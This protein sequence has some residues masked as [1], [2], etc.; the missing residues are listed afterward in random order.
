MIGAREWTQCTAQHREWRGSDPSC[1][2]H[3][4]SCQGRIQLWRWPVSSS[5]IFQ[6]VLQ[7]TGVNTLWIFNYSNIWVPSFGIGSSVCRSVFIVKIHPMVISLSAQALLFS[8]RYLL[9]CTQP[10]C[11]LFLA[12]GGAASANF[13][14][15]PLRKYLHLGLQ[16]QLH[17]FHEVHPS[18]LPSLPPDIVLRAECFS[19]A[20]QLMHYYIQTHGFVD[21]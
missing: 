9:K 6:M 3:R 16:L 1:A 8:R 5:I 20:L 17:H 19:F 21:I 18:I 4:C 10:H 13:S 14:D 7:S 11:V 2:N 15:F 12:F